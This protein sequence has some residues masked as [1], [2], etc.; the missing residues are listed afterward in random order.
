MKIV[1]L[2]ANGQLGREL[3]EILQNKVNLKLYKKK[4]LDITDFIEVEKM[5]NYEKPEILINAAAYTSVDNAENNINY[6]YKVNSEAPQKI[7]EILETYKG[8]LIHYST[9]YVYDGEKEIPYKEIDKT[10]PLNIYGKSKLE[11]DKK[12]ERYMT[13]YLIIRTSWVV[14]RY[15]NNFIKTILKLIKDNET[16]NIVKDQFGAPTSTYLIS[17]IT[18]EI[19]KNINSSKKIDSGIYNLSPRGRTNWYQMANKILERANDYDFLSESNKVKILPI[20]TID[21]PTKAKRPKNSLLDTNKIEKA[22]N[23]ELPYW[24]SEFYETIDKILEG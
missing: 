9:D 14:S 6:A 16:L 18:Y 19:I 10:N 20:D 4:D 7:A 22:L 13:N 23:I 2:G 1:I 5:I 11:G 3:A 15:G 12:I 8:Y 21:Y 24:E 17:K